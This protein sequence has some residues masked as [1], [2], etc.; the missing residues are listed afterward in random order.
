MCSNKIVSRLIAK[1]DTA[2]GTLATRRAGGDFDTFIGWSVETWGGHPDLSYFLDSWH[3]QFVAAAGTAQPPRNWQRW[4][5]PEL[6]K[7]IETVRTIGFD[8]PR[9]I[10]LGKDYI[11]LVTREMPTIPLMAYNVFTVMDDTYW[12]GWPTSDNPTPT[13][14]RTGAT[15]ATCWSSSSRGIDSGEASGIRSFRGFAPR[16][17]NQQDRPE[18]AGDFKTAKWLK[19]MRASGGGR[20]VLAMYRHGPPSNHVS[21]LIRPPVSFNPMNADRCAPLPF[22]A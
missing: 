12:T 3:S 17:E 16:G 19:R 18:A 11:K 20:F 6:D 13:R 9:G 2:Q 1:V 10:E 14:C 22:T 4:S 21:P 8:D 7:I 15:P 5:N